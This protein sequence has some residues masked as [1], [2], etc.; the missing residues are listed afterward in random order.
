MCHS[1]AVTPGTIGVKPRADF[2]DRI[3]CLVVTQQRRSRPAH[4]LVEAQENEHLITAHVVV[5]IP[6]VGIPDVPET[7]G[8]GAIRG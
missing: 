2:C 8:V 4:I 5:G 6:P 7:I 3:C 1:A